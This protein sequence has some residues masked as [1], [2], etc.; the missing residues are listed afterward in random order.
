MIRM[1]AL[2]NL[3]VVWDIIK[4][5]FKQQYQS[6]YFHIVSNANFQRGAYFGHGVIFKVY[7]LRLNIELSLCERTNVFFNAGQKTLGMYS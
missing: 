4:C 1:V 3:E 7:Y 5:Q 2:H 6:T